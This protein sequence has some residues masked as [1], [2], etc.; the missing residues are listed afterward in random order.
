MTTTTTTKRV[1]VVSGAANGIGAA[2]VERLAAQGR[3]L[4]LLDVDEAGL[5]RTEE[6]ARKHGVKVVSLRRD[7]C[8]PKQVVEAFEVFRKELG[9]VDILANI[10]GGSLPG[11]AFEDLPKE[12][13]DSCLRLNLDALF[14]CSQ[15]VLRDM[16]SRGWGRIVNVSSLAGRTR[17][18]FGGPHYA[19]AKAGVIGFTRQLSYEV[20]RFGIT[21][22][23]VAPGV[24]LS[25]RVVSKLEVMPGERRDH[26][27]SLIPAA[28]FGTVDEVAAPIVFLCGEEASY[29]CGAVIDVNG[30]LFIG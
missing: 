19:T 24:T 10:V 1:A 2:V 12:D 28:R 26:I 3:D 21:V 7:T 4:G 17:S 16:K 23:V 5:A 18:L 14:H 29:I 27:Q 22:N 9:P 25:D 30:G 6:L 20:A 15:A 11:P 8:D 13:W